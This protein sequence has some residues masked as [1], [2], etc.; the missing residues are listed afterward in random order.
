LIKLNKKIA[1]YNI[2]ILLSLVILLF[3]CIVLLNFII[4]GQPRYWEV[5]HNKDYNNIKVNN[6]KIIQIKKNTKNQSGY[7]DYRSEA[8]KNLGYSGKI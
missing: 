1:L 6:E 2:L 4:S 3:G 7:L 8:Y 5:V